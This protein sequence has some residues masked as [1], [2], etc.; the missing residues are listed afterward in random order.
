M[1]DRILSVLAGIAAAA[2][3]VGGVYLVHQQ[4]AADAPAPVVPVQATPQP[5]APVRTAAA[6][7]ACGPFGEYHWDGGIFCAG[8]PHGTF[9]WDC[10]GGTSSVCASMVSGG[11]ACISGYHPGTVAE[12]QAAVGACVATGQIGPSA[13]STPPAT[14]TTGGGCPATLHLAYTDAAG[15]RRPLVAASLV[16]PSG[17]H[18]FVAQLDSGAGDVTL[19]NAILRAAGFTPV[20]TQ[21]W[22]GIVPG[23]STQVE[24]YRL[25]SSVFQVEDGSRMVPL[26]NGAT[27]QVN[28]IPGGTQWLLGPNLVQAGMQVNLGTSGWTLTPAC[29]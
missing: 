3:V 18:A 11:T 27:I 17:A 9:A 14:T 16:G 25:P 1:A 6:A 10:I 26:G 19:P 20:G 13:G 28:G 12:L 24:V 23:A 21:T 2:A 5:T 8:A 22:E 15:A 4:A 29:G 7:S